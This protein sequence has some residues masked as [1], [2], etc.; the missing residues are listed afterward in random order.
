MIISDKYRKAKVN[1]K[2]YANANMV[3]QKQEV[4]KATGAVLE[5]GQNIETVKLDDLRDQFTE[6]KIRDLILDFTIPF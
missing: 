6:E 1:G 4:L 5:P 2:D 3:K